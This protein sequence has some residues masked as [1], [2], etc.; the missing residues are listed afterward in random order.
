MTPEPEPRPD[1]LVLMLLTDVAPGGGLP[2]EAVEAALR[3]GVTSVQLRAKTAPAGAMLAMAQ[4][5]LP[6]CRRAGVPLLIDDRPDVAL[7]AGADGVH[8]GPRDL[9]PEAARRVLGS[10]LLGV[11]ARDPERAAAAERA[12]ADYLGVGALRA[13]RTKPEAPPLGLAGIAFLAAHTRIP[14]V[15]VG[16]VRPA[17]LPALRRAGA[18][19]VAV[20]S[21]ILGDEDPE[22]AARAYREAWERG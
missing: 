19:G 10:G 3:G 15:A 9:P 12:A 14:V 21:G 16:G 4:D 20:L 22:A 17:D 7:A 1:P 13:T 11:S 8:V 18:A 6:R 2:L 5:L